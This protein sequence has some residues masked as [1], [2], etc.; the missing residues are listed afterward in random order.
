MNNV[1][2][3]YKMVFNS[4]IHVVGGQSDHVVGCI[5]QNTFKYGHCGFVWNGSGHNLH[6]VLQIRFF[7][8]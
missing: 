5:Y 2:I 6:S 4:Q 7:T 3:S 1:E 8:N